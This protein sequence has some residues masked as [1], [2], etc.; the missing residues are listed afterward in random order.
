M[1]TPFFQ[2]KKKLIT[3]L[4]AE[5]LKLRI[6]EVAKEINQINEAQ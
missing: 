3:N 6:E 2:Q 4:K 1:K 5:L